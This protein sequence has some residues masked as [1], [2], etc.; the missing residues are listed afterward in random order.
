MKRWTKFAAGL[1]LVL[2]IGATCLAGAVSV[3]LLSSGVFSTAE[4]AWTTQVPVLGRS[5]TV[6]VSGVAR[7]LTAP[8]VPHVLN[9]RS[10]AT[11]VGRMAFHRDGQ[12]L[13]L[14]VRAMLNPAPGPRAVPSCCRASNC[15]PN[16]RT[17]EWKDDSRSMA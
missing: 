8:G 1:A 12:A 15:V 9:G 16:A 10:L 11:R 14:A 5:V 17:R 6:N 13:V 7:L 3:T 2:A 4:P